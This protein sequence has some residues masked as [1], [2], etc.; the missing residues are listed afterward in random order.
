MG[1]DWVE[2]IDAL[3]SASAFV[4]F[5][6]TVGR[7]LGGDRGVTYYGYELHGPSSDLER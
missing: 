1:D 6:I 3:V 7:K 5:L 2:W 4:P